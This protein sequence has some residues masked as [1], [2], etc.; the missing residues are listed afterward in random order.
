MIYAILISLSYIALLWLN[1]T[2]QESPDSKRYF[3]MGSGITQ[4]NPFNLR[5]LLPF[6]CRNNITAWNV[7][8]IGSLILIP[9]VMYMLLIVKGYS[10]TQSLIGCALVCGLSGVMLVNYIA[11]YLT[12]SFGMLMVLCS[13]IAF[14]LNNPIAGI[15]F[16]C[17]G[18]MANEKVFI[19]SAL[20]SWNSLALIGGIPVLIRYLLVKP[21]KTDY[22]GDTEQLK[23]PLKLAHQFH[24][25]RYFSIVLVWGVCILA[26]NDM[27]LQLALT[28]F[29][30]Y[31]SCIG[32]TDL[33]RLFQW[34]FP[35]V[36]IATVN[37][38]P[39]EYTLPLLAIHWFNGERRF[40]L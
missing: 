2:R 17:I 21:A 38:F 31:L 15:I 33:T 28:L 19:Y 12:D 4:I 37:V 18:S 26:L 34:A 8:N 6:I 9:V 32:A 40:C 13:A 20:T 35:V 5:W 24:K 39:I 25:N 7:F 36:V 3:A 14:Q 27:T 23:H 11:K 16:S 1:E 22:L 30:A 10:E 29:V